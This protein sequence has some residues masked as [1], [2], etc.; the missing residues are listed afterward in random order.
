MLTGSLSKFIARMA[1]KPDFVQGFPP[2]MAIHLGALLP[3]RSCNHPN[4]LGL[5]RP[6]PRRATRFLLGFASGGACHTSDVT[7]T[8]VG[9]YPTVSPFP[10]GIQAGLNAQGSLFSVALSL[11][12]PR[13][14]VTRRLC[15]MKSG[16]SSRPKACSHP[17]IR[18]MRLNWMGALVN[19]HAVKH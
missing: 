16:L 3:K 15:F 7:T 19:V 2:S 14:G 12:L 1:Y 17:A 6:R 9:S 10:I 18:K 11:G 5:K 4:L 8:V 13:A